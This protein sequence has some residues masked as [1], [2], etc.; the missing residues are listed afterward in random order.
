VR[1][2]IRAIPNL[3]SAGWDVYRAGRQGQAGIARRQ[4]QRLR[5]IVAYARTHSE[6]FAS[7]YRDV[8]ETVSDITQLPVL[9][10]AEMMRHFEQWVTDPSVSREQVEAFIADPGLIGRD[11]LGRYLVCTTSGST[12][13]PAILL[14]D[15]GALIVYNVLGYVRSLPVAF[16]SWR[17]LWALVRGRGRLAAVFVTGGHF[18]GN[19]M[20]ARRVRSIPWRAETQRL[21]SA[22]SPLP[23]L[24]EELNA[25]QPV[26][27]GGYPSALET[28]AQEQQA[29]RLRIHPVLINAAGETFTTEARRHIA[30]AFGC[31]VGNHY[32]SSEAVGLTYECRAQQLH[33]NSDWYI[34]EPVDEHDRPVP[35]G[36]LSHDVLVTNLANRVQP[37]IRYR[38]GDRVAINPES[39]IC[40]SPFPRIR[41]IGRT[42]DVLLFPT[43][44]GEQIRILPLAIATVADETPG[45][46][47]CQLI[48]R[49]PSKLAVRLEVKNPD[50]EQAV[51]DKLRKRLATFLAEQGT[52]QV[53][54]EKAAEPPQLHPESGKFRQVFVGYHM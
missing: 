5:D 15:H 48:Q 34:V 39:C 2:R 51:W 50:E 52:T 41:V 13:S 31:R 47:S 25:F 11:Y 22:L 28:L 45:V 3:L 53:T 16:S 40:G 9:T 23:E 6:Y 46:A 54:I 1:Q 42:D 21:F 44:Q 10:K 27:L 38:L 32:G 49:Q 35:A 12:G 26:V 24:V 37:I 8:P 7:R 30:A 19:T 36:Q 18:L 33:L 17:I 43:P 29:D 20:M 4:E 14:H